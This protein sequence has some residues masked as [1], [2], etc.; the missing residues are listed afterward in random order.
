MIGIGYTSLALAMRRYVDTTAPQAASTFSATAA[1]SSQI[2]LAWTGPADKDRD[3]YI[4]ERSLDGATGWA[5][6]TGSPFAA[7]S[8]GTSD[9]G[10]S[11]ST[12]Y[13]YR[14]ATVDAAGNVSAYLT[15]NATTAASYLV[16]DTFTDVDGTLLVNHTPD[17]DTVGLGWN[18]SLG[19][20]NVWEVRTNQAN[21]FSS[22]GIIYIDTGA[23]N[24]TMEADITQGTNYWMLVGRIN[25]SNQHW[26]LLHNGGTLY[27]RYATTAYA[28]KA[29]SLTAGTVYNVKFSFNGMTFTATIDG[30]EQLSYTHGSSLLETQTLFGLYAA[31]GAG[32]RYDNLKII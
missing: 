7:T 3:G 11:G 29:L 5:A 17:V 4:L 14:L 27:I 24:V 2:D 18:G 16:H 8:T 30:V 10:L 32:T 19:G 26:N 31:V 1:S 13:Y 9:T 28:S 22:T 25:A 23:A 15:A 6:V 20:T 12:A 21:P